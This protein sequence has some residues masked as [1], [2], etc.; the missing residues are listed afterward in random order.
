MFR[1]SPVSDFCVVYLWL[2][3]YAN[4][5]FLVVYGW[6]PLVHYRAE[7]GGASI[8]FGSETD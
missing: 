4:L 5:K 6:H 8:G 2:V 1:A 3:R 7:V